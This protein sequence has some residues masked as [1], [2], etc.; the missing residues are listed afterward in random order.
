MLHSGNSMASRPSVKQSSS[1]FNRYEW[2]PPFWIVVVGES[3]SGVQFG[4]E[5]EIHENGVYTTACVY[6]PRRLL[7]FA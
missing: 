3:R 6:V 4:R 2:A 5:P 1:G 7:K